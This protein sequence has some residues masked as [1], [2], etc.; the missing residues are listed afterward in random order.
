MAAADP[1]PMFLLG[2]SAG[3]P[4]DQ[5]LFKHQPDQGLGITALRTLVTTACSSLGQG[6]ARLVQHPRVQS[7]R[8]DRDP[9]TLFV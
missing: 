3:T 5:S 1:S 2:A 6:E 4:S 7:P 8:Q 9:P